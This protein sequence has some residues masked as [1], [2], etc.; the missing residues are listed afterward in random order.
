MSSAGRLETAGPNTGSMSRPARADKCNDVGY[1]FAGAR[2]RSRRFAAHC[3][4]GQNLL[5][6]AIL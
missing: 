3:A 5:S 1:K 2:F 6:Q 4:A